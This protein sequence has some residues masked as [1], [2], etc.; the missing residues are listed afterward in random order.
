MILIKRKTGIMDRKCP[1]MPDY[2]ETEV[3]NFRFYEFTREAYA[4]V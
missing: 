4:S 3:E 1:C 2:D